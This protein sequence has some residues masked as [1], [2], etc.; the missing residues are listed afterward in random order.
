MENENLLQE[1]IEAFGE[2]EAVTINNVGIG[3]RWVSITI[4]TPTHTLHIP[5]DSIKVQTTED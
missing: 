2:V 5:I 1:I 3:N 4:V